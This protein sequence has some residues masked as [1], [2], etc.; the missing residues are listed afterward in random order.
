[1]VRDNSQFEKKLHKLTASS[2]CIFLFAHLMQWVMMQ[3][4]KMDD[5]ADATLAGSPHG[6]QDFRH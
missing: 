3:G 5:S 2:C 6:S 1:M 4:G